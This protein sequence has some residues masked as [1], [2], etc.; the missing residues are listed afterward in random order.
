M[1]DVFDFDID[2]IT[3]WFPTVRKST[4]SY[5]F[6]QNAYEFHSLSIGKHNNDQIVERKVLKLHQ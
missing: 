6:V 4:L 5:R 2:Q 1:L 3:I